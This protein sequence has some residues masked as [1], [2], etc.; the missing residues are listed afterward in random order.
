MKSSI[1]ETKG[2]IITTFSASVRCSQISVKNENNSENI[3]SH[4]G[5]SFPH[6]H[7]HKVQKEKV[8]CAENTDSFELNFDFD[9]FTNI[10]ST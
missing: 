7:F 2:I 8:H 9:C 1:I 3:A 5:T 6:F 10:K 4:R